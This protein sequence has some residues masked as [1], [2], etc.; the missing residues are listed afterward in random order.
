MMTLTRQAGKQQGWRL[1]FSTLMGSVLP[2]KAWILLPVGPLGALSEVQVVQGPELSQ[3]SPACSPPQHTFSLDPASV[4]TGRGRCP[5][6]PSRA[7]AST[8]I[9]GLSSSGSGNPLGVSQGWSPC[10]LGVFAGGE[11]YAGLTADFLGRDPGVFRSMGTRSA[12]R[13]EVDQ[14]LL[15]GNS[16]PLPLHFPQQ[17]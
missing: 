9:G 7:F 12:L 17:G 6:E 2:Q 11:L 14:R 8:V 5:H 4:E 13:T 16:F 1:P 3:G 15:N 10:Q